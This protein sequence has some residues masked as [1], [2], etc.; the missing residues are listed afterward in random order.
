MVSASS[1]MFLQ[2][3][4][5][6]SLLV[7]GGQYL[8]SPYMASSSVVIEASS[9]RLAASA[10]AGALTPS[11]RRFSERRVGASSS[12]LSYAFASPALRLKYSRYLS[13]TLELRYCVSTVMSVAW[14]QP[15]AFASRL[16]S[17]RSLFSCSTNLF[18]SSFG[19]GFGPGGPLH[20]ASRPAPSTSQT[21]DV[22]WKLEVLIF[23]LRSSRA[24]GAPAA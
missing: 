20:E 2:S 13:V 21:V 6:P 23:C 14:V 7:P 3:V 15:A 8:P 1:S 19:G 5:R 9:P 12:S 11:F 22:L 10:G 18:A 24:S 16:R 17:T 4:L